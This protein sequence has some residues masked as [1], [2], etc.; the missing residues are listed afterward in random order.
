LSENG[1]DNGRIFIVV[2]KWGRVISIGPI[3]RMKKMKWIIKE[4][5]ME[6]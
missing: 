5:S 3:E 1:N 6:E 4:S 2:L